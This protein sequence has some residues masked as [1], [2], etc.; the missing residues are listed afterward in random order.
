MATVTLWR[1]EMPMS[2]PRTASV[3]SLLGLRGQPEPAWGPGWV[4]VARGRGL[5]SHLYFSQ[6]DRAPEFYV[7]NRFLTFHLNKGLCPPRTVK[8]GA[9]TCT[10]QCHPGQLTWRQLPLPRS[11]DSWLPLLCF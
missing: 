6:T 3:S 7:P 2:A 1:A 10:L 8:L 9:L 4:G 11:A 5:D